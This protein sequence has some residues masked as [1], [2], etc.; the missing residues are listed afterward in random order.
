MQQFSSS[1]I[2]TFGDPGGRLVLKLRSLRSFL[3]S[4]GRQNISYVVSSKRQLLSS[5]PQSRQWYS[6]SYDDGKEPSLT[7]LPAIRLNSKYRENYA[8]TKNQNHKG[9]KNTKFFQHTANYRR[10]KNHIS[11]LKINGE[12]L[13]NQN[14]I[15]GAFSNFFCE[16][17]G[18]A[19]SYHDIGWI[20]SSISQL[21]LD[22]LF[23][24][25]KSHSLR[26]KSEVQCSHWELT[27][28]LILMGSMWDSISIYGRYSI[29]I[30][31]ISFYLLW[32]KLWS[33]PI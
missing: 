32:W 4:W 2:I 11:L 19:A 28:H 9:D 30:L 22:L 12:E 25:S 23:L 17:M 21:N 14:A 8:G 26:K 16:L 10:S 15:S 1:L 13:S 27:K 7:S 5:V 24:P 6:P 33:Y 31:L 20:R 3:K 18:M 29:S